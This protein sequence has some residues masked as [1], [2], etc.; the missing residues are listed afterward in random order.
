MGAKLNLASSGWVDMNALAQVVW[1]YGVRSLTESAWLSTE[2][3]DKLMSLSGGG[4]WVSINYGAINSHT[5]KKVEELKE[6]IAQIPKTDISGIETKLNETN[7]H[8]DIAKEEIIDT[9]N[10]KE[11][12]I[13]KDIKKTK[14]ELKEDNVATRQLVR[15]KTKNLAELAQKQLDSDAKEDKMMKDIQKE[16]EELEN[17]DNELEKE[18]ENQEMEDIKKEFE[19]QEKETKQP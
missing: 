1:E 16:F 18:F 4:G 5:T 10:E 17:E 3:H 7:S 2:E 8:I 9:I 12:S 19:N 14:S 15:Q 6:Q 11:K 13:C